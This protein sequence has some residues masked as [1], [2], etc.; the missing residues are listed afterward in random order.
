MTAFLTE[1]FSEFTFRALCLRFPCLVFVALPRMY[2]VLADIMYKNLPMRGQGF[3]HTRW[4]MSS[5]APIKFD[6]IYFL[7]AWLFYPFLFCFDP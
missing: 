6:S 7:L 5:L 3:E 1:P 2:D 4:K